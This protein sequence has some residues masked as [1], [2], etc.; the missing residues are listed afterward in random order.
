MSQSIIAKRYADALFQLGKEKA[1]LEQFESELVTLRDVFRGNKEIISFLNHP[2]FSMEQ[3]KKF[4]S[5]SFQSFSAEIVNTLKLLVERHRE[6]I[7][8]DMIGFYI[9]M[10]NDAKGIADADVYSVRELSEAEKQRIS[11]TFAPKV[12]KQSLNLTNIVDPSI[13]GGLRLRVGNR[14]FDGS[15]SGKLRRIERKLVSAN[16]R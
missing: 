11:E 3:K 14:I 7:I 6:E 1:K 15:V 12:G 10:M 8:V 5:D 4:V 13:L 16:N 2:R 9:E